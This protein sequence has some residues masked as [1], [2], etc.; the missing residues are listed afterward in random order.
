MRYFFLIFFNFFLA[1]QG[2]TQATLTGKVQDKNGTPLSFAGVV[3]NGTSKGTTTNTEGVYALNLPAGSYQMAF[4]YIGY[5]SQAINVQVNAPTTT[6]NVVLEEETSTL[7]EI[8]LGAEDPAYQIIRNAQAKRKYYLEDEY[9]SYKCKAYTKIFEEADGTGGTISLF[10][11][12][13]DIEKGI[14]YLSE[15]VSEINFEQPKSFQEKVLASKISGDTAGFSYNRANWINFYR[16][17]PFTANGLEFVSPIAQNSMD[18]YRFS[19]E[20][21]TQEG[22]LLVHKIE[23]IP[24]NN[25]SVAFKGFIYIVDETWRIH[26]VEAYVPKGNVPAFDSINIRQI[27][28]PVTNNPKGVWLSLSLTFYFKLGIMGARGYYHAL[29]SDYELNPTFPPNFFGGKVYEFTDGANRQK[30]NAWEALRPIPLTTA[31]IEDYK[32]KTTLQANT[33]KPAVKDSIL[34]VR[35]KVKLRHILFLGVRLENPFAK[36][37]WRISSLIETINFNTVEGFVV[38]P[39]ITY[40]KTFANHTRLTLTPTVRYGFS[41]GRF[42]AKGQASYLYAPKHLGLLEVEGGKYISQ[43]NETNPI[44]PPINTFY[45]I[46]IEQNF[47]KIYEKTFAKIKHEYE[48]VNGLKWTL[49]GEW[50]DRCNLENI[51]IEPIVRNKNSEFTPNLPA[52]IE[53]GK[54]ENV[55]NNHQTFTAEAQLSFTPAQKYLARPESKIIQG[56]RLPTFTLRYTRGMLQ[57]DFDALRFQVRDTWDWGVFGDGGFAVEAGKFLNNRTVFFADFQHFRGNQVLVVQNGSTAFQ[58]LDYYTFSQ[59][60]DY[61]QVHW[62]HDFKGWLTN[63]IS[64]LKKNQTSLVLGVNYLYTDLSGNYVE[65]GIGINRLFKFLRVDWW[66]AFTERGH[67]QQG[68]RIST[69]F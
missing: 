5:K 55:F 38:H 21:S 24:K 6:L 17:K 4:Q 51:I 39:F 46:F 58:L 45:T 28:T 52:H 16:N 13:R 12:S 23:I 44:F 69:P 42:Q 31:E 48:L 56:S 67:A 61:V 65:A 19:L 59:T 25:N 36:K 34:E 8:A 41:N 18:Y 40:E 54:R 14:F 22:D 27:Y 68:F 47:M 26:S 37:S 30:E 10:G 62:K 20:G 53:A 3:V 64:F 57:S 60:K 63:K 43:Y 1:L 66:N 49:S 11:A 2:F 35:N 32:F 7:Q 9:K 33:A 50:A 29:T 15:T